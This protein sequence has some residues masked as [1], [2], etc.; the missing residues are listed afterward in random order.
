MFKFKKLISSVVALS[1]TA[2]I[3]A[4]TVFASVPS[5]AQG[6]KFEEAADVL[7]ALKIMVGDAN[8]GNFR[9]NDSIIRS[10]VTKVGVALM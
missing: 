8:T 9:P 10:E 3:A 6:T 7:G 2:S 5:D 1:M 4:S